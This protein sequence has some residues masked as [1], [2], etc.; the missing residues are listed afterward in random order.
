MSKE[1]EKLERS[2]KAVKIVVMDLK[3]KVGDLAKDM[4][5][6]EANF[7]KQNDQ[8]QTIVKTVDAAKEQMVPAG[9]DPKRL[10]EL[11]AKVKS[12]TDRMNQIEKK[13]GD[14]DQTLTTLREGHQELHQ[15]LEG[16]G[17]PAPADTNRLDQIEAGQG[18]METK[19]ATLRGKL[20]EIEE[21]LGT[22]KAATP[23]APSIIETE[24]LNQIEKRFGKL[25]QTLATLREDLQGFHQRQEEIGP[26]EPVDTDRFDQLE[27]EQGK[28]ENKLAIL[29]GK[30]V[31]IEETLGTLKTATPAVS[32]ITETEQLN[33][34]EKKL[35]DLDQTLTT[36][37][38]G[39]QELHQRLEGIG[40]PAPADTNR[41]DQIEAGQ[42][43]METKMATL[44][45]KLAE[46]EET[47]AAAPAAPSIDMNEI[48]KRFKVLENVISKIELLPPA[49]QPTSV[50]EPAPSPTVAPSPAVG[51]MKDKVRKIIEELVNASAITIASR[52]QVSTAMIRGVLRELEDEGIVVLSGDIESGRFEVKLA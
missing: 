14:L 20:A 22:L 38:E 52:L 13:L 5:N 6:Q 2:I 45:G 19:M 16:I 15:R 39:H 28:T 3:K 48:I 37:S 32:S 26:S 46:I 8:F 44:R 10:N 51:T 21:T 18:E 47:L 42:G 49:A 50:P 7:K 34:I 17:T 24:Q 29:R 23:T 30:L 40:T 27:A 9:I 35:G 33:Q 41:L 25:D 31:E 36:L 1:I 11:D 43:E 4:K 12:E